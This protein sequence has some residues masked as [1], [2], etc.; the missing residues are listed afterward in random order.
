MDDKGY[1][2]CV[3][4]LDEV[5]RFQVA[6]AIEDEKLGKKF[7]VFSIQNVE[8][9]EVR[10]CR[11]IC[12][13]LNPHGSHGQGATFLK[14]FLRTVIHLDTERFSE[15]ELLD[16]LI[17]REMRTDVSRRIDFTIWIGN[18]LFPFEVKIYADDQPSQCF[19][20]YNF[21]TGI[22]PDAVVYYLTLDGHEPSEDSRKDLTEEQYRCVSFS[23]EILEWIED[24]ISSRS[25]EQKYNI[26][27]VLIQFRNSIMKI[28]G[29]GG[30]ESTLEIAKKISRSMDSFSAA[31]SIA[32][33][34]NTV[35]IDKMREVFA[36]IG[37][38]YREMGYECIPQYSKEVEEYYRKNK[39]TWPGMAFIVPVK[40]SGLQGRLALRFEIMNKLY[41]GVT[42]W[43]NG[44]DWR[45][46][47]TDEG[48]SYTSRYLT[49]IKNVNISKNWYWWATLNDEIDYHLCNDA[50]MKLYDNDGLEQYLQG[51]FALADLAVKSI[52]DTV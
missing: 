45:K 5:V 48:E 41:F 12:E 34:L 2:V 15:G 21:I 20:Y 31:V 50:Y 23:Q 32:N 38:H 1:E 52:F 49:P 30:R 27:E 36:A 46:G 25:I 22:D 29:L 18:R 33:S 13:L 4:L 19:D 11:L 10:V 6:E 37:D 9:D 24:C 17:K 42:P 16:A 7:N 44:D 43:S 39:Y 51:V 28:T 14:S 3:D 35:K 40:E 47:K 8:T 26:R